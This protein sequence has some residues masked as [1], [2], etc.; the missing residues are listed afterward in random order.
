MARLPIMPTRKAGVLP[1]PT[2][3][4][5]PP[6][7]SDGASFFSGV[8][9]PYVSYLGGTSL[10]DNLKRGRFISSF[11]WS[12]YSDA[13]GF[14]FENQSPMD[15][16]AHNNNQ[17]VS[18]LTEPKNS[19]K[20][21]LKLGG[22]TDDTQLKI[23][24]MESILS[25]NGI[26]MESMAEGHVRM[27]DLGPRG[28]G[29]STRDSV[30]RLK[31]GVPWDKAGYHDEPEKGGGNGIP[32]KTGVIGAY[33][34]AKFGDH[35]TSTG[36]WY[37]PTGLSVYTLI[38]NSVRD[39]A[40]MTHLDSRPIIAGIVQAILVAWGVLDHP[41]DWERMMR[42][43]RKLEDFFPNDGDTLS[44]RLIHIDLDRDLEYH[45][46]IFRTGC[47]VLESYSFTI[48]AYLLYR[49]MKGTPDDIPEWIHQV[50][51]CGGDCDSTAAMF[52]ELAGATQEGDSELWAPLEEVDRLKSLAA[53]FWDSSL[54]K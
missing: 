9:P 40:I 54:R 23:A 18:G 27:L 2:R 3:V 52:G 31:A 6:D 26:N 15:I 44:S 36:S 53:A 38:A 24:I 22:W 30:M 46:H 47:Y 25:E 11:M 13:C 29:G 8:Y 5:I 14:P 4:V 32:M 39:I 49:D 1:Q 50:V 20:K 34:A 7:G 16:Y 45:A 42:M 19:H 10:A 51:N 35:L 43:I 21:N 48:A 12:V 41:L 37:L 28:W 33:Y 17:W